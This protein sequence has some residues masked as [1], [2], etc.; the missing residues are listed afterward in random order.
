MLFRAVVLT[1]SMVSLLVACGST[2]TVAAPDK[3]AA[4]A[5][6]AAPAAPA[7]NPLCSGEESVVKLKTSDGVNL[8]ADYWAASEPNKGAVVLVHMIPPNNNRKGYPG[9]FRS[10]LSKHGLSVINVDRRG[11]GN[12][13]GEPKEAYKGPKGRLD[14]EAAVK[15]LLD[16]EK[17][18]PVDRSKLVFIG[19]SNGTTSVLDYTVQREAS[20]PEPAALIFMSPGGYTEGQ[21]RISEHRAALDKLPILWLHPSSEPWSKT[22]M[23][24]KPAG[25][26]FIQRGE[27]HGTRM[28][29]GK[30]LEAQTV[31]DI[32]GM[33]QR[34]AGSR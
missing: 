34:Y 6:A 27:Q 19:A 24:G 20:L 30:D 15:F 31:A 8:E 14:V 10:M 5:P 1:L 7:A 32:D 3:E 18:C 2:T 22:Y 13:E 21:N 28:F 26:L 11:A 23:G 29:D 17:A 16:G 12:S 9:R 33:V 25:W 4:A